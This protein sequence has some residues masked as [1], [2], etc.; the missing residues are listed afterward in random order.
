V[1]SNPPRK[2]PL[3]YLDRNFGSKIVPGILRKANILCQ[4]HDDCLAV[5]AADEEW[6]RLCSEKN[7]IAITKDAQ[8]KYNELIRTSIQ[9]STVGIFILKAKNLTGD[10]IGELIVKAYPTI[11]KYIKKTK[12]PFVASIHSNG[13]ISSITLREK[14]KGQA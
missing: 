1:S 11:L 2:P 10:Q 6:V 7:W 8:I 12:R 3:F 9:K 5:D 14:L 4:V 13:S